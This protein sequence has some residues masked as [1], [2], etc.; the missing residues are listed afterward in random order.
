M[1]KIIKLDSELNVKIFFFGNKKYILIKDNQNSAYLQIPSDLSILKKESFLFLKP[2]LTIKN[3]NKNK[4]NTFLIKLINFI[5]NFKKKFTKRL[6]L[7]GLGLKVKLLL[8]SNILELKLGFS[9]LVLIK[10]PKNLT[11]FINKNLVRIVGYNKNLVY[12]FA[13]KLKK[14]KMPDSYRGKGIRYKKERLTL[15]AFKK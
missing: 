6:I 8:P 10:I 14:A 7:K 3:S 5:K 4:I 2:N 1:Y 11:I 15:K 13:Y 12:N 9:H